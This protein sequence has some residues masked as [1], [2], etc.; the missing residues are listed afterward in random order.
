M[1]AAACIHSY[2]WPCLESQPSRRTRI[3]HSPQSLRPL[4]FRPLS[5]FLSLAP[6]LDSIPAQNFEPPWTILFRNVC[7]IWQ[8]CSDLVFPMVRAGAWHVVV[9]VFCWLLSVICFSLESNAVKPRRYFSDSY[10]ILWVLVGRGPS[11]LRFDQWV[12]RLFCSLPTLKGRVAQSPMLTR[13]ICMKNIDQGDSRI[14]WQK[15]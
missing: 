5:L 14:R 4:L 6:T 15:I 9:L 1:L 13:Y 7:P 2:Y 8:S 12:V 11:M 3:V 10:S